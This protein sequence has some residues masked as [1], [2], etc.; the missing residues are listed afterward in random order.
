VILLAAALALAPAVGLNLLLWFHI[1]VHGEDN[2]RD[3]ADGI[4]RLAEEHLDDAMTQLVGLG[5]SSEAQCDPASV[6]LLQRAMLSTPYTSEIAVLGQDGKPRCAANGRP[7]VLR[8][9][10]PE[11]DTA[12]P[13]IK[14]S[15][16]D[17]G[18]DNGLRM[19]RLIWRYPDGTGF[20]AL[21]PGERL[22]PPVVIGRLQAN[23]LAKILLVDG[24]YISSRLSKPDMSLGSNAFELRRLSE[25]Y[26]IAVSISV[27]YSAL[28]QSYREL[29]LYG[30][31]GSLVLAALILLGAWGVSRLWQGPER[32]I[33]QALH[34]GDFIPY[35]QPVIDLQ[36]GR[37]MGCE[38][39]VRRRRADGSVES[40]GSFIALVEATGQIFDI[41]RALMIHARDELADCYGDRPH[42][43]VSFNLVAGHFADLDIVRQIRELFSESAVRPQQIVLEIT[44]RQQLPNLALARVIISKLQDFGVRVAVDDVGTGHGGFSYLLKLGAD[45]MKMDKMF[46]D[47]IG[48]DRCSQAIIDTMVN[49]AESLS[50]EL[51]AEG[52]ETFEQAQYLRERG[53]AGAQGY[54][55]APPLPGASFKALITAMDRTPA[56][57][58]AK[59]EARTDAD[60]VAAGA[61]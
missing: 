56:G 44:E 51:I 45:Q 33:A 7:R 6:A 29:F 28:W 59:A 20:S 3:S 2:I 37:L 47:A 5:I 11:N 57:A 54:V 26:P 21:V 41:T 8:Q 31:A 16:V 36:T 30:N 42:L 22:I 46:V 23:F 52:V 18:A 10:S 32:D 58:A 38:V 40:P 49:L 55:F 25:R 50:M 13:H 24:T 53:V 12:N 4:L 15:V 34:R 14:L 27:P 60:G 1:S 61:A 39:L 19:V 43:K 17:F 48:T 35:Y 9:I